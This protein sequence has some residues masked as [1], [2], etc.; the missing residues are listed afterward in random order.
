MQNGEHGTIDHWIQEF[1][2]MPAGRQ[3]TGFGFPVPNDT[4]HTQTRAI[5]RGTVGMGQRISQLATFMN[6]T[7]SLGSHMRWDTARKGELFEQLSHAQ[8]IL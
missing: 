8:F 7:R 2:R 3:G 1:V 5:K 6:R 4:S